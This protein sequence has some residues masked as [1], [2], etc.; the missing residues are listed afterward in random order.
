[1][2]VLGV[3]I[4][5]SGV[6]GAIVDTRSGKMLTSRCRMQTP[7]PATPKALAQT[8][9][10]LAD[11]FDWR[12]PIGCGMP[13]PIK[14][15]RLVLAHNLD[16]S[17][18]GVRASPLFSQATGC[19]THVVN[20]AD[21]AGLAEMTFGAGKGKAGVVVIVTLGT[22]I[23]SSIFV[24][25]R[26][27]PNTELGQFELR[28]KRAE[29]RA[30]ARI[31]KERSLSWGRWAKR[32]QEYFDMVELLL[33]PDLVIVGGGVSRRADKFLPKIHLR[34]KIAP[35]RFRNE[36]GLIGAALYAARTVRARQR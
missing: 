18:V 10:K 15:G 4:G 22:G 30:S 13:G 25:G 17:W 12:G 20:D 34:A 1:M 7:V 8:L 35:A 9:K 33:W 32:L 2:K 27:L 28:G 3:D 21:A 5:G 36:A 11:H 29:L 23:G 26:L 31:R 19:P 24:D 14:D 16:K 6:K